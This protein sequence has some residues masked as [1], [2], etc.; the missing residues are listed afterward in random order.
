MSPKVKT[1][2]LYHKEHANKNFVEAGAHARL[3]NVSTHF[4]ED[5]YVDNMQINMRVINT[6]TNNYVEQELPEKGAQKNVQLFQTKT[7]KGGTIKWE[8]FFIRSLH[9]KNE[10]N[11]EISSTREGVKF[12]NAS[13][14]F[15]TVS[16]VKNIQTLVRNGNIMK[17][18]T[19][20]IMG[21]I[22]RCKNNVRK[23]TINSPYYI[24]NKEKRLRFISKLEAM[25]G[26][27]LLS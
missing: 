1:V 13:A 24:E 12:D 3:I 21:I 16:R 20:K 4:L 11:I 22:K 18:T 5:A 23:A 25:Q 15:H 14:P 9:K 7:P 8:S 6:E 2:I 26:I 10:L 19:E 17:N 27:D